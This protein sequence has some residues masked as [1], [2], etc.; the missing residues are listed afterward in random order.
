MISESLFN[1]IPAARRASD[2][3]DFA[4]RA[5]DYVDALTGWCINRFSYQGKSKSFPVNE[6]SK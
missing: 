1:A 4:P 3:K 2:V 5:V 6:L